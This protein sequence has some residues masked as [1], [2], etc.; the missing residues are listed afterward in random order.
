AGK[1]ILS[2]PANSNAAN[3]S[4]GGWRIEGGGTLRLS[5][6]G[7]LGAPLPDTARNTVTDLQLNQSTI[8]A[9]ASFE[10]DINR[11]T[12]INTNASTNRGDAIIDTHGNVLTW[13]GS[14]QGGPGSLRVINSGG[15]PGL[16]ILG[17]DRRASINPCGSSLRTGACD[18]TFTGTASG[19]GALSKEGT[20]TLTL[21][22]PSGTWTGG[23]RIH[24]GTL[25]LGRGG[26]N[27]L[28]PG[29]PANPSSVV[30]Q[31]GATLKF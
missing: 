30:I 19:A 5:A 7:N 17:T 18:Q 28:L 1:L 31:A 3:P 4:G 24:N 13:Y 21:D 15:S 9:G 25:Q 16:L 22:N 8:Q 14:L 20:G 6:D 23:T 12:K 10:L 11:R 2:N 27:G 26:S 29:T